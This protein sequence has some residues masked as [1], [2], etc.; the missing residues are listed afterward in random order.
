M[1]PSDAEF[2]TPARRGGGPRN[3]SQSESRGPPPGS[4][5]RTPSRNQSQGQSNPFL[6]PSQARRTSSYAR[7]HGMRGELGT[8]G[9][10]Q[11]FFLNRGQGNEASNGV[12]DDTYVFGSK[13]RVKEVLDRFINFIRGFYEDEENMM[14]TPKYMD[15]LRQTATQGNIHFS[16]DMH[17]VHQ[18]DP[19]LYGFILSYPKQFIPH[20][21][22]ELLNLCMRDLM[23]MDPSPVHFRPFNLLQTKAIRD[24]E[25]LDLHR[26]VSV[27]G[28]VTRVSS[29]IPEMKLATF[30][31]RKCGHKIQVPCEQNR[32]TDPASCENCDEK[33]SHRLRHALSVFASKQVIKLQESPNAIPEGETPHTVTLNT[34]DEMVDTCRPGDRTKITGLYTPQATRVNPNQT[35][36]RAVHRTFL[37]VLHV[38]VIDTT[39]MFAQTQ[40]STGENDEN[41]TSMASQA[42]G[43]ILLEERLAKE[44]EMKSL[45]DDP[46]IYDKLV[47]SLAPSIWEMEDVKKG[48]LCQLFGGTIKDGVGE[49]GVRCD[50]NILLV[51]D[52]GVSKSQLLTYVNKVSPRGIYTSGRGSSAVGLTAYIAKDPDTRETVLESGALALSDMGICCIDEFDK[53]SENARSMLL[54]VMEQQTISVAKA[55]I[56]STLNARTSIL[57]S[58]NPVGSKYNPDLTVVENIK[59]PPALVSRF[60]LIYLLLDVPDEGRDRRLATHLLALSQPHSTM[61][62]EGVIPTAKL[63]EY[64]AYARERCKPVLTR[65]AGEL[66]MEE[67]IQMRALGARN[68]HKT[69]TATPRQ[70]ESFIRLSEAL[71]K[72]QLKS[73]VEKE[74]VV[75]AVRLVKTALRSSFIDKNGMIDL[76]TIYTGVSQYEKQMRQLLANELKNIIGENPVTFHE[77][78]QKIN[79]QS[80]ERVTQQALRDALGMIKDEVTTGRG[81]KLRLNQQD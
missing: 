31:C 78:F 64:I 28:M 9:S 60:D 43:G 7:P 59:L 68:R 16:V 22:D 71:A 55:G 63:R 3:T 41:D 72:M 44:A 73:V 11:R 13:V 50:I 18:F 26:V 66:L 25:P 65:E 53:M 6:T 23:I 20:F 27:S 81:G 70:L 45:S 79:G 1:N 2:A 14:A 67:Y 76:D 29:I 5:F 12:T 36:Q 10:A 56:V 24:L 80:Q 4:A 21:D 57:A 32:V 75:E 8:P 37:E 35:R 46:L 62:M 15:L 38:E 51:G 54:E 42:L 77:L 17:H 40:D 30:Q 49:Q 58:A 39:R 19:K 33:N 48:V 34:Y 69:I 74:H 61:S 52:P 47:S